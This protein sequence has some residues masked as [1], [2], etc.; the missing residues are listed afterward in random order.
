M[1][2][3][4]FVA[5]AFLLSWL[6]TYQ[7]YGASTRVTLSYGGSFDVPFAYASLE[8]VENTDDTIL[9]CAANQKSGTTLIFSF[10]RSLYEIDKARAIKSIEKALGV[11]D[12]KISKLSN[13]FEE[14]VVSG[15]PFRISSAG[16][17]SKGMGIF[18]TRLETLGTV[19]FF[20]VAQQDENFYSNRSYF[21]Q[22][23]DE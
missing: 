23:L 21:E 10:T 8:F 22:T 7:L 6:C 4:S 19:S 15:M 1:S 9:L 13:H 18:D 20:M 11:S 5:A 16:S 12:L 14:D 3:K 17:A 2:C